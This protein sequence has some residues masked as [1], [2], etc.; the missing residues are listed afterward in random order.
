MQYTIT[1]ND[2]NVLAS[3]LNMVL[4]IDRTLDYGS[5]VVRNTNAELYAVGDLVDIDIT[6]G[7]TT[8]SYHF[9]V[10][11]DD[12]TQL[13]NGKYLHAVDIIELTKILEWQTETVRT[14]TQAVDGSTILNLLDVVIRLQFT[15]PIETPDNLANTRIFAI[16]SALAD[17]LR[18]IEAPEFVFNN[19][20]LKE[21]LME[22]FDFINA[23]P[24]LTRVS[25]STVLTADFF[26]EKGAQVTENAFSRMERFNIDGFSTALDAD[27]KN[28]YDGFTTVIEPSPNNYKKLS[29]DAGDLTTDNAIVKTDYPIVDIESFKVK[30]NV[31]PIGQT[32]VNN[33]NVLI[34]EDLEIDITNQILEREEWE[35]L[36]NKGISANYKDG[37]FRD[38]TLYFER[39]KPNIEGLFE[40]VGSLSGASIIPGRDK[41]LAVIQRAVVKN[42]LTYND[43]GTEKP[44]EVQLLASDFY[45][46]QVQIKYKA[47]FDSRT[48]VKRLDTDRIKLK[49][50]AYTGQTENVVRADRALGRLFKLQQL[51][52]NAEIMTAERVTV[53]DDLHN[54]SDYNNDDY[55]ITT[56]ELQCEKE[57]IIAK[58]L[59]T[60][61]YQK[62]SEFIGLNSDIRSNLFAIPN[63]TYRRNVFIENFV[64]IGTT[65]KEN[66]SVFTLSG[67][68]TFFNGFRNDPAVLMNKP[69]ELM[70]FEN[71]DALK[72]DTDTFAIVKS[73]AKYAGTNS[74]NFHVDFLASAVAGWRI[75][76]ATETITVSRPE[77]E[78]DS[79][80]E[81]Q[82]QWWETAWE[83]IKMGWN[84]GPKG[85]QTTSP[86]VGQNS[87][88]G[89]F[90]KPISNAV[91]Y[92]DHL[93]RVFDFGFKLLSEADVVNPQIYPLIERTNLGTTR[94][95]SPNYRIYK[96]AREELA[97]T[98]AL[99][100]LP[101]KDLE[102]T[103]IVGTWMTENNNLI[104][105][106]ITDTNQF[107][108]FGTNTPYNYAE[109]RF[110]RDTDTILAQTYTINS[111]LRRLTLSSN[112]TD[113]TT[114]GIR[115]KNT[116]ELVLAV[117]QG[118]TPISTLFFNF[119]K[120]QAGITYPSQPS[121]PPV[122]VARPTQIALNPPS[123]NPTDTTIQIV[124]VD[125]NSSP[126]S[127]EFEIG[128]S[129]DLVNW[130]TDT[131]APDVTNSFTFS[132]LL[133]LTNYT[134]RIRARIGTDYSE[135]AYFSATTI[136]AGPGKVLNV[137]A[138]L[139]GERRILLKW[140][141]TADDI[142]LYR[143]EASASSSFSPLIT[144]GLKQTFYNN[145]SIV[146]DWLNSGID[147]D[148]TY[149]FRIRALRDGQF[150]EYSDAVNITTLESPITSSPTITNVSI[151]GSNVSYTLINTDNQLVTL[152]SDLSDGSTQRQ[153]NVRPNE[154][155]N[156]TQSFTGSDDTIF[157]KAKASL[158]E[159][160]T[161]VQ[162]QFAADEV[163]AAPSIGATGI[164]VAPGYNAV[165]WTYET[166]DPIVDGFV[167]ERNPNFVNSASFGEISQVLS[168]S[169]RQ[170][171]DS[172]I[173]SG[174]S[175]TYR[176]RAFN[177]KGSTLSNERTVT[178]AQSVPNAPSNLA[179][180][181][182]LAGDP[183]QGFVTI[184]W[185]R[186]STDELGF[187]V[188]R[189]L[190][191]QGAGSWATVGGTA[192]GQT[193]FSE[194]IEGDAFTDYD[195]R[196]IAYNEFG[197]SGPS[198]TLTVTVE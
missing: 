166:T 170:F 125:G 118:A 194:T 138:T 129:S 113:Y 180:V 152:F 69:I 34:L 141:E 77:D 24:R 88:T 197:D 131:Q 82:L 168:P 80:E 103:I 65:S 63:D 23:I 28:L 107:E 35:D 66:D 151:S 90:G 117:N 51:L 155:I 156:V 133:P 110:S 130:T 105:P 38:N 92:T 52:G 112:I 150:G 193:T 123:N 189:K 54:L 162:F 26:N 16:D 67:I 43:N 148:Q 145:T 79:N 61:Y 104:R 132:D 58:Y 121:T 159:N 98:F 114:W 85:V 49:S 50:A 76:R 126:A 3:Q 6:D 172:S 53:L 115:K 185:Q 160:S 83:L 17:V 102:Q 30:V 184:E 84:F 195:Y 135:W 109:N 18:E 8:N 56:I 29:S 158:K 62:V 146:F 136:K 181:A 87:F 149:Y 175:Y 174:Q 176:I 187:T 86:S 1:I 47:Q 100:V 157:A 78:V 140:D 190:S 68:D 192:K 142:F 164:V 191:S 75:S 74:I 89:T 36:T 42:E 46:M 45:D 134:I 91:Y 173:N 59:W 93:G 161:V 153:T 7:T 20:N 81:S 116:H 60:Q 177:R 154:A 10:S 106:I 41:I 48:E 27:I 163:P 9:I 171:F 13:P 11:A 124:W 169:T 19:K 57:Y 55:V 5:F 31:V 120:R 111:G 4:T 186:N 167:V 122:L 179:L 127:D 94:A 70:V 178:S 139:L 72:I 40:E 71:Q 119:T 182:I 101:D 25:G 97:I 96:D 32:V 64:Q 137:S 108:V 165:N 128:I 21:I 39:F 14:F 198:N 196:I 73:V 22:V 95:E 143:I 44:L 33:P 37:D 15:A 99:Q 2:S 12:V 144:N 183:G 147:Y 188:Q